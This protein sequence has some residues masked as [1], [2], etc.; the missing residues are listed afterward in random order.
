[1]RTAQRRWRRPL[2]LVAGLSVVAAAS[3]A[4]TLAAPATAIE[5]PPPFDVL[6][7]CDSGG[8]SDGGSDP[9]A[10]GTWS[11]RTSAGMT[12][13]V[14]LPESEPALTA[15]RAL[16]INLHGCTQSAANLRDAGNWTSTA[17]AYGMVVVTPDAPDGGVILGCWD[18]YDANHSRSNPSRHDDN[19]LDL[20]DALLADESLDVDPDQ[21]YISGLSSGGGQTMVMGCLAPDVFAGIGINAG[22]TVGTSAFEAG[23]V[24]T[25]ATEA[26]NTCIGFAGS[27]ADGFET[28]V[29]SVI[30][31]SN[32]T[33]AATGYNTLNAQ[34][35][36]DIYGA[37]AQSSFS[38]SGMDG[39]NTSGSGTLWSDSEGARVSLIQNTGMGH[40]WPA[41]GGPGGSYITTNSINYPAYL[42]GFLFE[43]NRR[44]DRE[45]EPTPT[46]TPTAT[47]TP[48]PTPTA[49]PTPTPTPD[50]TCWTATNAE[51]EAAGHAVSYGVD[52][53]NPYYALGSLD[54]LGLGDATVTS[55]EQVSANHYEQVSGC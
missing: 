39:T 44:V 5:C 47:P 49:T 35:M 28:Q 17:D 14:Y 20:V 36:S 18:Y 30:Y 52:P 50:P 19:L 29:T 23:F 37:G 27:H 32:D 48:T 51:H 25:T 38:L 22:P 13:H 24:A 6:P 33:I 42:T 2:V 45:S 41:G 54:Y 55:L 31:G 9:A 11:T 4:A 40:N 12:T 21:V 53:Y 10:A 3:V 34:V 26:R 16:M 1:M 43:N 46:P 7:G 8:G 15:G